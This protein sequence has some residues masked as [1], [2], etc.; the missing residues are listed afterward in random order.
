MILLD[1]TLDIVKSLAI[2]ALQSTS[3]PLLNL[4]G[5][6]LA[7]LTLISRFTYTHLGDYS[8]FSKQ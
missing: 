2:H 7:R 4:L 3:L 8:N 5:Y 1:W 6:S